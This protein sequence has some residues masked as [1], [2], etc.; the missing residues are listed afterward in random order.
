MID[1]RRFLQ[2]LLGSAAGFFSLGGYAFAV[3]PRHR[4]SVAE[5]DL[6]LPRWPAGAPPL[7]V[8]L[9]SDIHISDPWMPLERVEHIVATANSLDVDVILLLG[10]YLAGVPGFRRVPIEAM[11]AALG[12]LQAPLGVHA[13]VGNHD[14]RWR[15]TPTPLVGALRAAGI[16]VLLNQ[17]RRI[18]GHGHDFWLAGTESAL[19][20]GLDGSDGRDDLEATLAG[21]DGERPVVLMAHEPTQFESVSD[22]VAVTFSGHTHGG[23]VAL[24]LIGAPVSHHSTV[25]GWVRGHYVHQGRH[26][27]VTSG[28]GMSLLPIRFMVPPEIAVVTLRAATVA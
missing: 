9:L 6:A 7:K 23:Q 10:D 20:G 19:A 15:R 2:M 12:Q 11:A 8:A 13:I 16:D 27:V 24:P 1:R 17:S 18:R 3:E 22:R 25:H 21:V 28:L 5:Y 14:Y 26:L 4:L